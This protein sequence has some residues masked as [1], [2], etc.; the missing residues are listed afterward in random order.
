MHRLEIKLA[1]ND[2]DAKDGTFS[3]Y[4]AVFGNVDS[5]GDVIQKG[6]F[7]RTLREWEERGK[8][9]PMLLQHGGGFMGNADDLL[10]IGKWLSMEENSKGLK[11]EGKLFAIGTERGQYLYEGLKS[12][13]LDG[14]SIGYKAVKW[15]TRTKPDQP[16]RTLEDVELM[17]VSV[18]TFPAN[19]KARVG[20][21]KAFADLQPED[22]REIEASLRD[23]GLSR[24]DAVR[25]IAGF[26][27]WS[28]RDVEAT[29]DPLR[30]EAGA[31]I[32]ALLRRN[33]AT[34]VPGA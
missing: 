1:A 12:G 16:K 5:Y 29:G 2:I 27:A 30:D 13:A 4:G 9:P 3:G 11:V 33:I 21:V 10:P 14:L 25:A 7:K 8:Y 26:K 20:Q 28:R 15:S 17:E 32:A 19:G 6:A 24:S 31:E 18:V 34:F 22:F 23:A